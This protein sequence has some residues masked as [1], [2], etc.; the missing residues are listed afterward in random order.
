MLYLALVFKAFGTFKQCD[1]SL[2]DFIWWYYLKNII[3]IYTLVIY[4][5]AEWLSMSVNMLPLI[6]FVYRKLI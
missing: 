6:W 2:R 1:F 3:N 4:I 5:T